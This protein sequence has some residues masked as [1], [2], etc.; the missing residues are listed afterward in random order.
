[1]LSFFRS[2][3]QKSVID[4][5][6]IGMLSFLQRILLARIVAPIIPPVVRGGT[7]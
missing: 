2:S 7:T 3:C 4:S 5:N 6:R 1:M